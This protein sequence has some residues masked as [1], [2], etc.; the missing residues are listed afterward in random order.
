MFTVKYKAS[1]GLCVEISVPNLRTTCLR[2]ILLPTSF[3]FFENFQKQWWRK[4]NGWRGWRGGGAGGQSIGWSGGGWGAVGDQWC[5]GIKIK[6]FCFTLT[7]IFYVQVEV[8]VEFTYL[9]VFYVNSFLYSFFTII[10]I[11]CKV[12]FSS[13]S[14][15]SHYSMQGFVFISFYPF[16]EVLL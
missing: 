2:C 14:S 11:K 1:V 16:G 7:V 13:H 5:C 9:S 6:C 4:A 8:Q 10:I 12:L 3:Q 15:S